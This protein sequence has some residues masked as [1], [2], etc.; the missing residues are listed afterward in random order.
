[1]RCWLCWLLGK[2]PP[3]YS[4]YTYSITQAEVKRLEE[5]I[6]LHYKGYCKIDE[7]NKAL[8]DQINQLKEQLNEANKKLKEYGHPGEY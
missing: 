8:L 7:R 2:K 1:M 4:E 6:D 5:A 3:V